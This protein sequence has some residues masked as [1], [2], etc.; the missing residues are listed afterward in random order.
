LFL[1][2][3]LLV[4]CRFGFLGIHGTAN[5]YSVLGAEEAYTFFREHAQE[6]QR[7][8]ATAGAHGRQLEFYGLEERSKT[9][10]SIPRVSWLFEGRSQV[11]LACC[12]TC[13]HEATYG[14]PM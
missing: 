7:R 10:I 14:T 2:K 11:K 13:A 4:V 3:C 1:T 9:I 12:R 8:N 6:K 5:T